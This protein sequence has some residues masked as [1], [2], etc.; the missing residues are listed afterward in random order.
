ML[1]ESDYVRKAE[2]RID[3]APAASNDADGSNYLID[4]RAIGRAIARRKLAL[5]LSVLAVLSAVA[6]TFALSD[7]NYDG[8]SLVGLERTP[9]QVI[10]T[11]GEVTSNLAIDMPS[12]DTE[13]AI[14]MSPGVIRDAV[15]RHALNE[16][17]AFVFAA[18]SGSKTAPISVGEAVD[19]II[20][21]LTAQR[22]GASYVI[23]TVYSSRDAEVAARV[24]NAIVDAYISRQVAS[25]ESG[26]SADI[27]VLEERLESLRSDVLEAES[28]VAQYRAANSLVTIG[29]E[30]TSVQDEIGNL[31]TQLAAARAELAVAQGQASANSNDS[32]SMVG[33][34]DIVRSLRLDEARL[35]TELA[36]LSERYGPTHPDRMAVATQLASTREALARE[37]ARTQ[38]GIANDVAVARNRVNALQAALNRAQ[39]RLVA[40]S[41][42]SVRLNELERIA[43]SARDLYQVFLERYRSEVATSGIEKSRAYVISRAAIP[44]LPSSPNPILFGLMALLGSVAI[45]GGTVFALESREKGV[46]V[47]EDAERYFGVP[48]I[49]AIPDLSTVKDMPFEGGTTLGI[50]KYVV[51]NDGS[52]FNEAFRSIRTALKIGQ[53]TQLAKTVVITSTAADEGKTTTAICLARTSAMAGNR[54]LLLDADTRRTATSR[55]LS[56]SAELG[57]LDVLD[58]SATIDDV[59]LED[60]ITGMQLLPQRTR[61]APNFD[62]LQSTNMQE[63]LDQLKARYDL[64]VID[65]A[66]VLPVA[67][68]KALA[69]MADATLLAVRWRHTRIKGVQ[70]TVQQLRRAEANLVGTLM[71]QVDL[72]ARSMLREDEIYYRPYYQ[73]EEESTSS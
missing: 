44:Q 6:A 7:K 36:R 60:E 47:R 31:N 46:M 64:V 21:K 53:P 59:L 16:D 2:A 26:R 1:H 3:A 66:P 55:M 49:A 62:A 11:P 18:T 73:R 34:S 40:G 32:G 54:T 29:N 56:G 28:A 41:N 65:A 30:G 4:F 12:V 45:G 17:D 69:A 24:T 25:V 67:E 15:E 9:D 27:S 13:V 22:Q 37:T 61:K 23:E 38:Q 58:G 42:A 72:R 14:L 8:I 71:T 63:L 51:D 33:N 57:L 39:G 52:V 48:V 10:N 5:F 50:A 35:A 43:Q 19:R 70:M 68:T 20:T